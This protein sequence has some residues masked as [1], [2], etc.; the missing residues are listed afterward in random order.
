MKNKNIGI[1]ITGSGTISA[2]INA[3]PYT[4]LK[5]HKNY[6]KIISAIKIKAYDLMVSL[7]DLTTPIKEYVEQCDVSSRVKIDGGVISFDGM[8][9]HN[10]LTDRILQFM[11]AGLPFVPLLNF[12]GLLMDNPSNRAVNELYDFLEAGEIPISEDGFVLC[13]KNLQEDFYSIH[14]NP[15]IKPISG[16]MNEAGQI[17]NGVG[18]YIEIRRNQVNE[19][20]EETCSDGL[21]VASLQYLPN[22]S[23]S[24]NGKTVICKVNPKDFCSIPKDYANSKA[25]VCAYT[26]IS[27]YK[28]DYKTKIEEGSNGF[29]YPLYSSDGGIYGTKPDGSNF[30][31]QR[32]S[33]GRFTKNK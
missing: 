17:Y 27:E 22:F 20:S 8:V 6:D 1:T 21:H 5:P 31:N 4:V 12:F 28:E 30:Y 25:R 33:K 19:N 9:I 29:D 15:S 13:F 14:G 10:T 11:N 24:N 2:I 7:I 16:K 26:V 3:K 23:C 18:E 32:D